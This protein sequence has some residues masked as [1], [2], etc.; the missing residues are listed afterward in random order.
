MRSGIILCFPRFWV[1]SLSAMFLCFCF[2][3]PLECNQIISNDSRVV[4][5][6]MTLFS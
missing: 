6:E 3:F 2:F 5:V 1:L 4:C